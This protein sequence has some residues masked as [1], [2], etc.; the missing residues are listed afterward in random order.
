MHM[1]WWEIFGEIFGE[2][3]PTAI[4]GILAFAG[5]ALFLAGVQAHSQTEF[6]IGVAAF[7]LGAILLWLSRREN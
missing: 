2:A 5:L 3:L 7:V 6:L 4:G 1:G